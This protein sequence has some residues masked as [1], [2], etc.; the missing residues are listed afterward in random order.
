MDF[1]WIPVTGL[2][3]PGGDG[4][5]GHLGQV[6]ASEPQFPPIR[7]LVQVDRSEV[8][9]LTAGSYRLRRS[10]AAWELELRQTLSQ[11]RAMA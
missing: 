3:D 6:P 10:S 5:L 2:Q 8:L 11:A 4:S 1:L 7:G 9:A